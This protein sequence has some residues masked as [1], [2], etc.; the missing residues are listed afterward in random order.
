MV[1]TVLNRDNVEVAFDAERIYKAIQKT[2][3]YHNAGNEDLFKK[4]TGD[5]VERLG[6]EE[7][8]I[9]ELEH[10]QDVVRKMIDKNGYEDI[11]K[12]FSRYRRHH[13]NKRKSMEKIYKQIKNICKLTDRENA[14]VGNGPSSKLLQIAEVASRDFAELTLVEDEVIEA[15]KDNKIYPHDFSWLSVGTTTC[16]FI[17]FGRLLEKGFNPGHGTI[18]T[19]KRIR[20]A[21][22]LFCI[23]FQS[24]QNDQ[25]GGQA[26]G[27]F[28]RDLA[29]FV[30]AEYE[31]Q[32][33]LILHILEIICS[34]K[35]LKSLGIKKILGKLGLSKFIQRKIEKLAWERTDEETFQTMES[36][37]FNLNTMH[38]RAGSQVPFT[39]INI[40]DGT[41]KEE[42]MIIKNIL[43]AYERGLGKGEQ[44][45]FPNIV[46][47]VKDGINY[48]P[49]TPNHDMLR[50]AMRVSAKRLFPTY[51]FQNCSLNKG[52]PGGVPSMG[53]RT[54]V[55]YDRHIAPDKQTCEGRGNLSFTTID[56][57]G[58]ALECKYGNKKIMEDLE[59]Q[60]IRLSKKHGI[61]IP[62]AYDSEEDIKKY[63]IMLNDYV[64]LAIR[65][66]VSRFKY[67]STFLVSDFPF[68][69]SGL[70][71]DSEKLGQFDKVGEVLKHG[72]LAIGFIGLAETL[73]CL[74]GKHHGEDENSLDL[75]IEVVKFMAEKAREASELHD[76]NFS[77]IATPAEGLSGKLLEK[78][79]ETYGVVPGVT[80]KEWYTNSS[81]VPVEFNISLFEK[82]EI[83]GKFIKYCGGGSITYVELMESPGE[84]ID[85]IYAII[86]S[87]H[88]N[89]IAVG[90]INFPCDR[91]LDCGHFG[92]IEGE[93]CPVCGGK[94]IS[95]IR[96]I[97]GY[98]AEIENFNY[99]KFQEAMNRV[100]HNTRT[101]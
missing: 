61:R 95:R 86:Q 59:L 76:L 82:I 100:K 15:M 18:R 69:M 19:P 13:E 94:H 68:L 14:N 71:M 49:G 50:L 24:N 53:C 29:P 46:F 9:V 6:S 33:K 77:V 1:K 20:T 91:C 67:Q 98:L 25:H 83:E 55:R 64:D 78:D 39:S 74:V 62:K 35:V 37:V 101:A 87:M 41:S 16:L 56:I 60:F 85:A 10:I 11:G 2:F 4:I 21:G 72:T 30:K 3:V 75:G 84:N 26:S 93:T 23:I 70:W 80:D 73:K 31:Y 36:I 57:P 88:D 7:K 32:Y 81:H 65:Q 42:R 5:V 99:A 92:L 48:E 47:K 8:D 97:T 17:P 96:R 28:E 40:G 52:F 79:R 90:A 54:A 63:F 45:L 38:S 51:N 22:Q 89:D 66:L 34:G 58:I 44:P 12:A 27:W 43:L